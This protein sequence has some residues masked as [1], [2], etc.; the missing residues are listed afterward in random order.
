MTKPH[1]TATLGK[2]TCARMNQNPNSKP[3]WEQKLSEAAAR[4]EQELR[5]LVDTIDSEVVP[6]VRKHST[7]A[8][9]TL[10]AKL[11]QLADHMEEAR[12]SPKQAP[13]DE[14]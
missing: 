9:R 12:Q 8:L 3:A 14:P 11:G 10:S 1:S 5:A 6:E 7:A 2:E 4:I 13:R